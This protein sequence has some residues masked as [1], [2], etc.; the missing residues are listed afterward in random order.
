MQRRVYDLDPKVET[1]SVSDIQQSG[2]ND[3]KTA[4]IGQENIMMKK[5]GKGF[6]LIELMIVVAIIGILA[7]V[8]IPGFMSYIKSS[9]TSEAK[10]NLKAI[11]DGAISYF[12]AEHCFDAACMKPTN[13]LYPGVPTGGVYAPAAAGTIV[14]NASSIG[15]KQSPSNSTDVVAVLAAD[16]YKSLNFQIN[17]PFY[18]AYEYMSANATPGTSTFSAQAQASLNQSADSTFFVSG[19]ADGKVGNIVSTDDGVDKPSGLTAKITQS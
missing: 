3:R 10:T 9:K 14:K 11:T 12:E 8:A 6:T 18:Y 5:T 7:A 2:P 15:Q 16:P 17:K 13:Q 19:T 1:S 4:Q